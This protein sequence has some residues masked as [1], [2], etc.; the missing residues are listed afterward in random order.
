MRVP[1][2]VLVAL[3][4]LAMLGVAQLDLPGAQALASDHPLRGPLRLFLAT[5]GF[6]MVLAAI[7]A[8]RRAFTTVDPREPA[9]ASALVT[10]GIFRVSRNPMYVGFG[11]WLVAWGVHLSN[12]PAFL[13]LPLFFNWLN[14]VQ[15][16]IEERAMAA[17]F[18]EAYQTYCQQVRRWL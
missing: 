15:I 12:L 4:A 2:L 18:G 9:K 17:N 10:T 7:I 1:P 11:L 8:F 6:G 3:C 13:V 16:P 14:Q 5:S